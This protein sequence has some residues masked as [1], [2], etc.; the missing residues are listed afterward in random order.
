MRQ[1]EPR[2]RKNRKVWVC[3]INGRL[4]TLAK[5]KENKQVAWKTLREI[6]SAMQAEKKTVSPAIMF[7]HLADLFLEWCQREKEPKTYEWYRY[8]VS[9]FCSFRPGKRARDLIPQDINDWFAD[10]KQKFTAGTRSR[11]IEAVNRVLNWGVKNKIIR[12]NPIKGMERPSKP[13]REIFVNAEQRK[14]IVE[15]F[16]EG[17]CFRE[18]LYAMEQTGCR[19]GEIAKIT[20]RQ[21]SIDNGV[22]IFLKHKTRNQTGGKPRVIYL[23]NGMVELLKRLLERVPEGTPL[24][25][26]SEGVPWTC[27]AICQRMKRVRKRVKIPGLV[28]YLWRHGFITQALERGLSDAVVA[29]LAGHQDTRMIHAFYSHLTDNAKLLREAANKAVN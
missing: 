7:T 4:H 14:L 24:F 21:V 29:A 3:R 18:F 23:S 15:A 11:A 13:R 22:L 28:S 17:D 5:G 9:A 19:P 6:M 16:P 26:N 25:R 1:P 8:M 12:E 20:S 2:W 10:G 27:S